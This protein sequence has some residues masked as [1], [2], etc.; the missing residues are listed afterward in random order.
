[1]KEKN[2]Y[3]SYRKQRTKEEYFAKFIGVENISDTLKEELYEKYLVKYEVFNRDNFQCQNSVCRAPESPL[4]MHHVKWQKNDGKDSVRNCV[5]LC[6]SCH[7]NFHRGKFV[8]KF[9]DNEKLPSH[10]RGHT[11][12]LSKADEVN[13][14]QLRNDMKK[15]RKEIKYSSNISLSKGVWFKMEWSRVEALMKMLEEWMKEN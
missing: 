1:M 2:N 11:F 13:W 12:K 3:E 8:I 5:I 6:N 7:K 10:I 14:K 9:S 4:E 15:I